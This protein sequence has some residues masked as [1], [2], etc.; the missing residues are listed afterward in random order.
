MSQ[1]ETVS[2][3]GWRWVF[4]RRKRERSCCCW[5]ET[6]WK[7]MFILLASRLSKICI[8]PW[9]KNLPARS[10][11]Y[12][13]WPVWRHL[14]SFW[15]EI[16]REKKI[17]LSYSKKIYRR[18]SENADRFIFLLLETPVSLIPLSI[19]FTHILGKGKKHFPDSSLQKSTC[20]RNKTAHL[21][22]K[23]RCYC[24]C[25]LSHYIYFISSFALG[26]LSPGL[27]QQQRSKTRLIYYDPNVKDA[28][29]RKSGRFQ[30]LSKCT[31]CLRVITLRACKQASIIHGGTRV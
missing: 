28:T 23:K 18:Q 9:N 10:S 26:A 2:S 30:Q 31:A 6:R 11:V 8:D 24:T 19:A 13:Y 3:L 27:I 20:S 1:F 25:P 17:W 16:F 29:Q 15:K 5:S 4:K 21:F 14:K 22:L 7:T 12:Q